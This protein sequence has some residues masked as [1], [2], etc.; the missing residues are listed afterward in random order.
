M[1]ALNPQRPGGQDLVEKT[2]RVGTWTTFF[3][4]F[5]FLAA[6]QGL[7]D[8]SSPTRDGTQAPCSGSSESQPLD[9]QGSPWT[10]FERYIYGQV[11][12]VDAVNNLEEEEEG[13]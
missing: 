1:S 12:Y 9:R 4:I 10:T 5:I 8:L 13:V 2:S 6:L 7:W 3:L 11:S